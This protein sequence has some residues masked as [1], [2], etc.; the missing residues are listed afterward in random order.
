MGHIWQRSTMDTFV[1]GTLR[2][3]PLA[4]AHGEG[5]SYIRRHHVREVTLG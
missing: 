3:Q 4:L 1:N 2:S 5:M